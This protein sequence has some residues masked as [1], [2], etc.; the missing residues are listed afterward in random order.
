M[1]LYGKPLRFNTGGLFLLFRARPKGLYGEPNTLDRLF[2]QIGRMIEIS[3]I[4][5]IL[6]VGKMRLNCRSAEKWDL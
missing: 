6:P 4:C 5:C 1:S 3:E 2:T